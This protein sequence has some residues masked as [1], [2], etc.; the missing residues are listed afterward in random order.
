MKGAR[1]RAACAQSVADEFT[2]WESAVE[3]AERH[4][5]DMDPARRI[6]LVRNYHSKERMGL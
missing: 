2:V 3:Q 6:A 4:L 5:R 1:T